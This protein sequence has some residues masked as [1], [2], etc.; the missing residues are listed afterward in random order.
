MTTG[1][2]GT[3]TA[4]DTK[5]AQ[6]SVFGRKNRDRAFSLPDYYRRLWN[7]TRSVLDIYRGLAD[8]TA[9]GEFHPPPKTL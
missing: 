3:N 2:T 7:H 1:M 6:R 9:D 4:P 8:Y 5:K